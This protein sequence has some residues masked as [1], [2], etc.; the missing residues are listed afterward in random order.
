MIISAEQ[1]EA[2]SMYEMEGASSGSVTPWPAGDPANP[3]SR[4]ARRYQGPA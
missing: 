4:A 1:N 2:P 3:A